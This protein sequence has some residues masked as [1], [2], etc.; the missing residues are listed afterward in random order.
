M[1]SFDELIQEI[2]ARYHLGPKARPLMHEA[3]RLITEE[4][5]GIGGFLNRFKSAGFST[6]V[7][8]W[9]NGQGAVPLSAR[10]MEQTLGSDVVYGIAH[11]IGMSQSF[12]GT[13]LGY[14]IPKIIG[15]LA[16]SGVIP[17]SLPPSV[18]RFL[19]AALLQSN[20]E[21]TAPERVD[22]APRRRMEGRDPPRLDWL[23]IPGAA[24]VI[25]LGLLGYFISS[26]KING[27]VAVESAPVVA[28]N[29]PVAVPHAPSIPAR[30]SLRNEDGHIFYS[31]TVEDNATRTAISDALK[32][33]F[34]T[35]KINGEVTVDPHAGPAEWIKNLRTALDNF[36]T[37]GSQ[38]VFEGNAINVGGTIA[39]ADRDRILSSLKSVAGS[40][41]TIAAMDRGATKTAIMIPKSGPGDKDVGVP[42][43]PA[44]NF[45]I[46]NF[47][48]NRVELP[49]RSKPLLRQVAR[50]LKQLPAGTV[51]EISSYTG[52][53]G[54]SATNMRL[55]Q[56]RA[57]AV[58]RALVR[59]GVE[60]AMLRAKGYGSS[61]SV[62]SGDGTMEGRSNDMM[63]NRFRSQRRVEF[64]I[65][66]Q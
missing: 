40:Q 35:N 64:R 43:Q 36:K 13:V 31:G 61:Q 10:Q 7:A 5:G 54:N 16:P 18:S 1:A 52:S 29:A 59:E 9:L 58:R 44:V 48:P 57:D 30:L 20:A 50:Q 23:L 56:E 15:F 42:N 32:A 34:R 25:T 22:R 11:K 24:L 39:D 21:E 38:A 27:P 14:T 62:A 65:V 66:Q 37:P 60:P 51:V 63:E 4:P 49:S 46:I 8:S 6:E 55:S 28:Q 26:G 33:V 3:L 45:P 19:V 2:G 41:F 53:V 17:S 47:P 12:T